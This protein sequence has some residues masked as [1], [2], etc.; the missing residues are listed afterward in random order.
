MGAYQ[1]PFLFIF[2]YI[3][4]KLWVNF[5]CLNNVQLLNISLLFLREKF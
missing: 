2:I 1:A 3:I 5:G 4:E